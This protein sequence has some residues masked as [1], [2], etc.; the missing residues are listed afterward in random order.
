VGEDSGKR[1]VHTWD[2]LTRP[3]NQGGVGFR[4]MSKFNQAL[5]VR[6]AWRLIQYPD[7][8]CAKLLKV[9]YYPNGDIVDTVFPSETSPT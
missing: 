5:L 1:K 6:Q 2:K 4:D 7:S 9:R 8:L 3:K